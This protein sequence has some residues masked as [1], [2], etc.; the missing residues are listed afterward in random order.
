MFIDRKI[1]FQ[2]GDPRRGDHIV[3]DCTNRAF[4]YTPSFK[5]EQANSSIFEGEAK[6][7]GDER[8][9]LDLT[10]VTLKFGFVDGSKYT[11][12]FIYKIFSQEPKRLFVY[13]EG[14]ADS[15]PVQRV[16][17]QYAYA[18]SMPEIVSGTDRQEG[19]GFQTYSIDLILISPEFYECDNTLSY[20]VA[21]QTFPVYDGTYD[22]DGTITYGEYENN[23]LRSF[24]DLTVDEQYDYLQGELP[25]SIEDRF[26]RNELLDLTVTGSRKAYSITTNNKEYT[27]SAGINLQC[28]RPTE[29]YLLKLDSLSL[30]E[31][32]Q[33]INISNNS[34]VKI[35]WTH[36]LASPEL[37][38]N[39]F[40]DI[41][42]DGVTGKEIDFMK[43]AVDF[44]TETPLFFNPRKGYEINQY[45]IT[46]TQYDQL[47][48]TKNTASTQNT[49]ISTLPAFI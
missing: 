26:I 42:F 7:N 21:N 45:L 49:I 32:V 35:T 38:Y 12:D 1:P 44:P 9:N 29:N 37:V 4:S 41:V 13:Q 36:S 6:L 40:Y 25:I 3:F 27:D 15:K 23:T 10:K 28:S 46:K 18:A 16:L 11:P 48:Y 47:E 33:I 30:N 17:W 39:S 43:Y 31:F 8:Q 34:S 2:F 24:N 20:F 19:E 22:Y 5:M 14:L